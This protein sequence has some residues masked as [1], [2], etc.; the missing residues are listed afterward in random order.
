MDITT[1]KPP[2]NT[3]SPG[4][5]A[6]FRL[7]QLLS[8]SLPIG[9]YAYSQGLEYAVETG[10]V[11][12]ENEM[13]EWITGMVSN[14]H[15]QLDVPVLA[16]LYRAWSAADI[17]SVMRWNEYLL[18]TRETSE[19]ALE[20]CQLGRALCVL[21]KNLDCHNLS[22]L[23]GRDVSFACALAAAGAQ[24][25]I[26]LTQLAQAYIWM[27]LENQ[28]AA[29]IKLVPLGQ[30]A[31]QRILFQLSTL[32]DAVVEQALQVSDENIGQSAMA[33]AIASARHETQYT[34]IFRS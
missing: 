31:G 33:L 20:D 22:L 28:V 13:R 19:L 12:D 3:N 2:A 11:R 17:D 6:Q 27:W 10:W 30:T 25:R 14:L 18:A 26:P 29:A 4:N 32:L 9:N 15:Q 8:P 34:R 5:L 16:R 24:W 21:L 7:W 1:I 23:D